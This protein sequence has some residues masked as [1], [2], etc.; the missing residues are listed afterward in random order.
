MQTL[1][2]V[3]QEFTTWCGMEINVK[4]KTVLLVIDKDRKRRESMLAP[5]LRINVQRLKMLDINDTCR[6]PGSSLLGQGKWWH[7]RHKTGKV[8][9]E[10]VR[11]PRDLIKSHPLTSEL[12][13]EHFAQKG[14]GAFQF[15][16][17]LIEWLQ[18]ELEV[19]Q[20]IWVQ[21]YKNAWHVIWSTVKY[22]YTFPTAESGHECPL[23]SGVLT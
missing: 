20:K 12:S 10:K 7:E 14:I 6:Y 3:V 16:A 13:A 8:D 19:L 4:K 11:L 18:S 22:L 21:A 2:D 5:D 15:L 1:F 9:C 23:S 17:A